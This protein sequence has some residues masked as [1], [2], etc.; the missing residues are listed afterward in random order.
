M[1]DEKCLL[2]STVK[3]DGFLAVSGLKTE[4]ARSAGDE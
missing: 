3:T 2:V 1:R 4:G